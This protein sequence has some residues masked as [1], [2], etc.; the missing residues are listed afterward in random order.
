MTAK[1]IEKQAPGGQRQ[2]LVDILPL[3]TPLIMQIFPVYGCVL[4]CNYCIFSLNKEERG[5]ISDKV[6]LDFELFRKLIRDCTKFPDKF[7]VFRFVGIGEPLLHK[8]IAEMVTLANVSNITEKTEIITNGILLNNTL[9]DYL[10][11]AG[12]D[13][14]VV[15][16]QG[17]TS[18]KYHEICNVEINLKNIIENLTYYYKNKHENQ[19]VY[20]K[21]ADVALSGVEDEAKFYKMFENICD[22]MSVE[23][24]VPLHNIEYLNKMEREEQLT[25]FGVPIQ[26]EIKICSMPLHFM[27]VN[28]DGNVVP[29]YSWEYPNII[30]NIVENNI[31]DIWN[32][33]ENRKCQR[34][35]LKNG[36]SG[37]LVCIKCN[38]FVYRAF[39]EDVI[40]DEEA[41]RLLKVYE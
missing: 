23:K 38:M 22:S 29:C 11:K 20:I 4:K 1:K 6:S 25:Q 28:P 39:S 12:L 26:S 27:Q 8:N 16:I 9:S 41:P 21:I 5:F 18:E 33:E 30:G 10:I 35:M 37:N 31:V 7:K 2:K 24:I 15:S 32:S 34:N 3:A 17:V 36:R 14:L 40:K 19:K 13:Q